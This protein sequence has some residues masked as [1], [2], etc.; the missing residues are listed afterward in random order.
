MGKREGAGG[1][2]VP[3]GPWFPAPLKGTGETPGVERKVLQS[4]QAISGNNIY[5]LQ[6]PKHFRDLFH[7]S[8]SH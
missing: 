4:F 6:I 8:G 1:G 2:G 5:Y 3:P 7:S